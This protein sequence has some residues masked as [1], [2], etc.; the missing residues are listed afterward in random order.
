MRLSLEGNIC[1]FQPNTTAIV[2]LTVRHPY[3]Q[4]IAYTVTY[5]IFIIMSS[6]VRTVRGLYWLLYCAPNVFFTVSL[7]QRSLLLN[8]MT[9]SDIEKGSTL[10]DPPTERSD[11][12]DQKVDNIASVYNRILPDLTRQCTSADFR[13]FL[14]A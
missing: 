11:K 4:D 7:S 3:G 8:C 1:L 10:P 14:Y 13:Y 5:V 2:T 12:S 6:E 9:G